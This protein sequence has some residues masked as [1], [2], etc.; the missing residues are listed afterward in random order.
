[1]DAGH[2]AG[3]PRL[4][5]PGPMLP[6]TDGIEPAARVPAPAGRHLPLAAA[7]PGL[8][9]ILPVHAGR[10]A[11][12]GTLRRPARKRRGPDGGGRARTVVNN[13]RA[14]PVGRPGPA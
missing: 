5:L 12:T 2:P 8:L 3:R 14:A 7:G 1:M 10:A 9:R 6:G 4:A 13:L 11:A